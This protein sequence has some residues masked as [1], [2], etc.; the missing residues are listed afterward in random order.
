MNDAQLAGDWISALR[1]VFKCQGNVKVVKSWQQDSRL[2][3]PLHFFL[4]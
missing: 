1:K 4:G 2:T 3:G